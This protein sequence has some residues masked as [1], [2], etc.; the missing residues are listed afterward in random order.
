MKF[1]CP[2]GRR[3]QG[4]L[5][6][7]IYNVFILLLKLSEHLIKSLQDLLN[8]LSCNGKVSPPTK[9]QRGF[10]PG[11]QTA[12]A[13]A[14]RLREIVGVQKDDAIGNNAV[15]YLDQVD[16]SCLDDAEHVFQTLGIDRIGRVGAGN[17]LHEPEAELIA[18][19]IVSA[20]RE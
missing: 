6:V 9:I 12:H 13:L 5:R 19:N 15:P 20:S 7:E 1:V 11:P 18:G 4:S 3:R 10:E 8:D 2:I 14:G 17:K 16:I